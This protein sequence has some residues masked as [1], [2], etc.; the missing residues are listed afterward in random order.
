MMTTKKN[1]L[2]TRIWLFSN[3]LFIF[4]YSVYL[5]SWI[6]ILPYIQF[7]PRIV[8]NT[9]ISLSYLSALDI[10]KITFN[11]L[12]INS[13]CF[14]GLFFVTNPG[15]LFALPFYILSIINTSRILIK[16][17]K[18]YQILY[19]IDS[20]RQILVFI[21]YL[22]QYIFIIPLILG[23]LTEHSKFLSICIYIYFLKISF[24]NDPIFKETL[25][26]I[27]FQLDFFAKKLP[28]EQQ[29]IYDSMKKN[30]QQYLNAKRLAVIQRE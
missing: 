4:L 5:L 17:R 8:F 14:F 3:L 20:K 24:D 23:L 30:I 13:N 1:L 19:L 7:I 9:I 10:T 6:V 29:K 11:S 21:A 18:S 27:L 22:L 16:N 12:L 28:V 15:L 25:F 26:Y 2:R